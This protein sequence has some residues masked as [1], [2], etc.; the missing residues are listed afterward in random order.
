V[1]RGTE[2]LADPH[3]TRAET[4]HVE[5]DARWRK[6]DAKSRKLADA[7][8]ALPA[9]STRARVTSLNARWARAAEARDLRAAEARAQYAAMR[10]PWQMGER[11]WLA[12]IARVT[13][14]SC[15]S[16]CPTP[17]HASGVVRLLERK[18]F[19]KFYLQ[20]RVYD[21]CQPGEITRPVRHRDVIAQALAEGMPVPA[22]VLAEY[23]DLA[24]QA[25]AAG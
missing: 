22:D 25:R 16:E 21:R 14:S 19:L 1:K 17:K 18:A 20:A 10:Q 23:P 8:F 4:A 5:A 6:L 13:M 11:E 2:L 7:R 15:P 24:E 12:E 3:P 9:G